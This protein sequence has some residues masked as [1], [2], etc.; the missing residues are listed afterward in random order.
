MPGFHIP[1]P[2]MCKGTKSADGAVGWLGLCSAAVLAH[3]LA[4]LQYTEGKVVGTEVGPAW[5]GGG[6]ASPEAALLA[7]PTCAFQCGGWGCC[8][9]EWAALIAKA[10]VPSLPT[11]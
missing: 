8:G 4:L 10:A 1:A 6:R 3:C 5:A 2:F 9:Q 11:C 7:D